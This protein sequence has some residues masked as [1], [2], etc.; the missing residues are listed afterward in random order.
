M[1]AKSDLKAIYILYLCLLKHSHLQTIHII[2]NNL[3]PFLEHVIS[4]QFAVVGPGEHPLI[5]VHEIT[6]LLPRLVQALPS[7]WQVYLSFSSL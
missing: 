1:Q 7:L 4:T 3:F 6:Y 5:S 2:D